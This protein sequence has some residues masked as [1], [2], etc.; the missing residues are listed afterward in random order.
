MLTYGEDLKV[1]SIKNAADYET[2]S[3]TS[4]STALISAHAAA[5][6]E[7]YPHLTPSQIRYLMR[8]GCDDICDAGYDEKS[9]YGVF[10]P[11]RFYENL[12]LFDH[13]EIICFYDVERKRLVL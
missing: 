4:Y 13:G 5:A 8:I 6:L 3:G 2:I 9:G 12:R 1:V 7:Q 11:D 10:S